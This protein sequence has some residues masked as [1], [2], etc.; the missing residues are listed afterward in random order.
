M[1]LTLFKVEDLKDT[2]EDIKK[3]GAQIEYEDQHPQIHDIFLK[4]CKSRGAQPRM[5][6]F[7]T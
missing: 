1:P 7:G 5:P 3:G 2:G 4:E 6:M